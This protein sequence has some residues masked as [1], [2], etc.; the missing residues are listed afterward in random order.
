MLKTNLSFLKFILALLFLPLGLRADPGSGPIGSGGGKG[1][2][3]TEDE[4]HATVYLADTF[5]Y[6]YEKDNEDY[7]PLENEK[8]DLPDVTAMEVL[9]GA[10]A[11]F[12]EKSPEKIYQH[13]DFPEI[14]ISFGQLLT[15]RWN[16]LKKDFT[17][18]LLPN[19]P[20]DHIKLQK[21]P[22]HCRQ[23]TQIAI[24]DFDKHVLRVNVSALF[25][26]QSVEAG[27]LWFHEMLLA[28]RGKAG[29]TTPIR[30]KVASVLSEQNL[31]TFKEIL[32]KIKE[33]RS[34]K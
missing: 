29:D 34:T 8:T 4:Y 28:V 1:I 17:N 19:V 22:K 6:F 14:K 20:D 25:E 15:Y 27:F 9:K 2:V 3:C 12:E 30:E 16:H 21:L 18:E 10:V 23:L 13:P 33:Q 32:H 11:Y 26:L 24:Q 31:Q 7:N 5:K